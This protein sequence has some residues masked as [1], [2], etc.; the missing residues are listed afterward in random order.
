MTDVSK[1][2]R[3]VDLGA[4]R[5]GYA[6]W[7]QPCGCAHAISTEGAEPR[8]TF[9]GNVDRPTFSPSVK[10]TGGARGSDHVCHYFI[11]AGVIK[12]CGD[13]THTLAGQNVDLSP[14]ALAT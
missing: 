1:V 11:E 12:Y 10:V 4:G 6:H 14:I 2:L 3:S 13:S 9:D 8:W 7:C 5:R